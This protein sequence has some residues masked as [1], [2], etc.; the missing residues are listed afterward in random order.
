VS[1]EDNSNGQNDPKRTTITETTKPVRTLVGVPSLEGVRS[2]APSAVT[3]PGGSDV[4]DTFTD[5]STAV[6]MNTLPPTI[7]KDAKSVGPLPAPRGHTPPPRPVQRGPVSAATT[8]A[9]TAKKVPER[10]ATPLPKLSGLAGAAFDPRATHRGVA[11]QAPMR[12]PPAAPVPK[13]PGQ[14]MSPSGRST[15]LLDNSTPPTPDTRTPVTPIRPVSARRSTSRR[16]PT[17]ARR[18]R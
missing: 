17:P 6:D 13:G 1:V 7:K 14:P 15:L 8:A 11:P 2:P 5:V 12:K 10:K 4:Q 16:R 9:I 3:L 18:K